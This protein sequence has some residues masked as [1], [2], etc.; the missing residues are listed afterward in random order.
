MGGSRLI[1][2]LAASVQKE[3]VHNGMCLDSYQIIGDVFNL[4]WQT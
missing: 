3:I 2:L 4:N 1:C